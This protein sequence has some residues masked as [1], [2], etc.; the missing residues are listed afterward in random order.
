MR[1]QQQYG[2]AAAIAKRDNLQVVAHGTRKSDGA[3]VYAV[4]SRSKANTW[5]LIVVEGLHLI[6]DCPRAV[7]SKRYC[8]HRAA[9][10]AR[11]ELESQVRRD[12]A[13]SASW[14]GASIRP[15]ASWRKRRSPAAAPAVPTRRCAGGCMAATGTVGT[16]Q[17]GTQPKPTGERTRP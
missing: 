6:C 1:A 14:S 3:A 8:A 11:L 2:R 12:R 7:K 13:V 4:P 17:A 5:H 10:R 9:V 15:R 16:A